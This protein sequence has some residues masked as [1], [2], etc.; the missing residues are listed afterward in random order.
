MSLDNFTLN[1]SIKEI[2]SA[3]PRDKVGFYNILKE[4]CQ[5][6]NNSSLGQRIFQ[7]CGAQTNAFAIKYPEAYDEAIGVKSVG[8]LN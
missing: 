7:E 5:K 6:Y 2:N 1:S 4:Q 3:N 8:G